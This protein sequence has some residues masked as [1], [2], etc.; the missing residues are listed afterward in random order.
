MKTDKKLDAPL[1]IVAMKPGGPW[2]VV[3]AIS[4]YMTA[5]E[6]HKYSGEWVF[7][8]TARCG[9]YGGFRGWCYLRIPAD[10]PPGARLCKKCEKALK[11]WEEG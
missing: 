10:L 5:A 9:P 8:A 4:P 2:H 7:W 3:E 11:K 6:G 1:G